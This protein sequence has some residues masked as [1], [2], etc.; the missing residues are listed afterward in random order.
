MN[1]IITENDMGF[2]RRIAR[3]KSTSIE[4]SQDLKPNFNVHVYP[5][6]F[7]VSARIDYE[8]MTHEDVKLCIYNISGEEIEVLVDQAQAV[9]AHSVTFNAGEYGSGVFIYSLRIGLLEY[10]GKILQIK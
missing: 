2:I 5:N 1:I 8:L 7:K 4:H 6:P 10:R 9:G 3:R